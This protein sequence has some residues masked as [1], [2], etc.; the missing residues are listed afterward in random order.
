MVFRWALGCLVYYRRYQ[1]SKANENLRIYPHWRH[2]AR[3]QVKPIRRERRQRRRALA[4]PCPLVWTDC[5]GP[6]EK[7]DLPTIIWL[8]VM[9][10]PRPVQKG[11]PSSPAPSTPAR[12][13]SPYKLTVGGWR[14]SEHIKL[15]QESAPEAGSGGPRTKPP[16]PQ[17]QAHLETN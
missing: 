6:Q 17:W 8:C 7:N 15:W 9:S 14:W 16:E 4:T 12:L 1:R 10:S 11:T 13:E 3:F 2:G 5:A